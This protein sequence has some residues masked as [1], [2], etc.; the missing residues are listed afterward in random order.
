MSTLRSRF[1]SVPGRLHNRIA[2]Y[3]A[4]TLTG[5]LSITCSDAAIV[6]VN[7]GDQLLTDTVTTDTSYG[8][9]S[10]DL[11]GDT[12]ADFRLWTRDMTGTATPYD[13]NAL[14]TAPLGTGLTVGV[15]GAV[16]G[17]FNYPSRLNAGAVID[18][19]AA[20]LTLGQVST[21]QSVGWLADGHAGG[22]GY[23]AS[24]WIAAPNNTGFLGVRFKIGANDHF[25]WVRITVGP[26]STTP[27][28]QP[29]A[30]TVHEW[31]YEDVAGAGIAAG[32]GVVPEPTSLGLLALGSLGLAR[33][34]RRKAA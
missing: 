12:V 3:S 34:R 21:A 19:S 32:S 1:T 9:Y 5:A 31:A 14:F 20:F 22:P 17:G 4:T 7:N 2:A 11:N 33:H 15:M 18:G 25:A 6:Y 26:Q 28:S 30:I 23:S 16:N 24:Q 13:N 10:F 29:R 27:G 8:A